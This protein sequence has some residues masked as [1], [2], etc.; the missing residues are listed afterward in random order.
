M[1]RDGVCKLDRQELN[2]SQTGSKRPLIPLKP[3]CIQ[4]PTVAARDT[5]QPCGR[6]VSSPLA[7]RAVGWR[8]AATTVR[9]G[10]GADGRQ[11]P[12]LVPAQGSRQTGSKGQRAAATDAEPPHLCLPLRGHRPRPRLRGASR[13]PCRDI[14]AERCTRA[15]GGGRGSSQQVGG[16]RTDGGRAA[17]APRSYCP[18][19]KKRSLGF[20]TLSH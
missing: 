14:T 20:G 19:L 5:L 9:S 15:T 13:A 16:E 6:S 4:G 18:Q 7:P 3:T 17:L 8:R 2:P 12:A 10:S 1:S 11:P